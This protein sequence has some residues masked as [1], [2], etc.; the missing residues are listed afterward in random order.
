M[1]TVDVNKAVLRLLRRLDKIMACSS[2]MPNFQQVQERVEK[3]R[4]ALAW[5]KWE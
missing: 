4:A 1:T 5:G 2:G 3:I